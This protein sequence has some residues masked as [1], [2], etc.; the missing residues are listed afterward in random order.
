MKKYYLPLFLLLSCSNDST[1]QAALPDNYLELN[2]SKLITIEVAKEESSY[3]LSIR[4]IFSDIE[5]SALKNVNGFYLSG[6]K[7]ILDLGDTILVQDSNKAVLVAYNSN[8]DFLG[9]IGRRGQGPEEYAGV[10]Y[11]DVDY[12]SGNIFIYSRADQSVLVYDS[13]FYFLEKIR[14]GAYAMYFAVIDNGFL[15]FYRDMS[16]IGKN[17]LITDFKGKEVEQ[18]MP[19]PIGEP[20]VIFGGSGMLRPGGYY[21]YPLSSRIRKL[22]TGSATDSTQMAV[23]FEN[24]LEES[25][26]FNHQDYI[27]NPRDQKFALGKFSVGSEGQEV[28]FSYEYKI[29]VSRRIGPAI[30]LSSG[31]V[32]DH[33]NLK[34][35]KDSDSFASLFFLGQYIPDYSPKTGYYSLLMNQEGMSLLS[36]KEF[37]ENLKN[38]DE[39]LYQLIKSHSVDEVSFLI[40]FKLKTHYDPFE[41]R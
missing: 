41:E 29:G 2:S 10:W 4:D 3:P 7:K 1:N 38:E 14:I 34:L 18:R 12:K 39:K 22:E 40:K 35:G 24:I 9:Q 26:I 20:Y 23:S 32:F 30:R 6:A 37:M 25:E 31:Q 11:F 13:E 21:T 19:Y 28:I 16:E 33:S 5:Y 27:K 17:I 15:A 8:G 36:D